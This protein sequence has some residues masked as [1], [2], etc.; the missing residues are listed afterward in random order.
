MDSN[1]TFKELAEKIMDKESSDIFTYDWFCCID[2]GIEQEIVGANDEQ[3]VPSN[4]KVVDGLGVDKFTERS[5]IYLKHREALSFGF[6]RKKKF[7]LWNATHD[8]LRIE[9]RYSAESQRKA[10]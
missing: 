8:K 2:E 10:K 5:T 1:I 9:V 4:Q 6:S 7:A 3:N